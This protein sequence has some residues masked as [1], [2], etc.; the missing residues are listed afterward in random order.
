MPCSICKHSGHNKTTCVNAV[1]N[2]SN[3][4]NVTGRVIPDD[5]W[6]YIFGFIPKTKIFNKFCIYRGHCSHRDVVCVY[7]S[8]KTVTLRHVDD[9]EKQTTYKYKINKVDGIE[10]VAN[11]DPTR[12][13]TMRNG[14][15]VSSHVHHIRYHAQVQMTEN[16]HKK[17]QSKLDCID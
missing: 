1:S 16:E 4:T 14:E 2:V 17:E 11:E 8:P 13:M 3:V 7:R 9:I 5:I 15:Y 10:Y 12:M 6:K